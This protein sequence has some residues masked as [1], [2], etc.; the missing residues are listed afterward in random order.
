MSEKKRHIITRSTGDDNGAAYE[1]SFLS[2]AATLI[3]HIISSD[4]GIT[5][6]KAVLSS[7]LSIRTVPFNRFNS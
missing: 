3:H 2:E 5:N 6:V 7:L 1:N 4:L